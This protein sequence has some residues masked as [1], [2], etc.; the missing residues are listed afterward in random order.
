M[1]R[2]IGL[3]GFLILVAS[4]GVAVAGEHVARERTYDVLHYRIE[5]NVDERAKQI[6]GTTSITLIPLR[7]ALS[8]VVL[9]AAELR[10]ERVSLGRGELKFSTDNDQLQVHLPSPM[11]L[12]DTLTIAVRYSASPRK[13]LYFIQPDSGYPDR[14]WQV[15][16]QGQA[17]DNHFWFPCYDYPNDKATSEMIVTVADRFTTVS[18]GALVR[19]THDK[20]NRTKTFHWKQGTPHSSYL[21]SL[22]VGEYA[23]L[24]D[25]WGKVPLSYYIYPE[26]KELARWSFS[27][28]PAMM[29]FFT[30]RIGP[31]PWERYAQTVVSEFIYGGMENTSASTLT[32]HTIHD[33]RAHLDVSSDGLVAHELAHQWWGDLLTCRDW[34]H[35]WLNEGFATY[36]TYAFFEADS[37][38]DY[39]A[40]H[41]L[42]TQ[43]NLIATD[44]GLDRRAIVR[45]SFVD[46]SDV[47][48][49]R[50]YGKG[51]CVLHMMRMMLGDQ[52]FTKAIKGYARKHAYRNVE[53]NDL[54]IA[55]E[56]ETGQNLYWFFNQWV[57]R[58][59]Y[60]EFSVSTRWDSVGRTLKLRVD[61]TQKHEEYT[62]S[63]SDGDLFRTPVDVEIWIGEKADVERIEISKR[64]HEFTF[65]LPERPTLVVFDPGNWI[66]KSIDF[67]R[68][69][70]ELIFQLR[71]ARPIDRALAARA[72]I[73]YR[74][75]AEATRALHHAL[76]EDSFWPVR[77][78]A[79]RSLGRARTENVATALADGYADGHARVREAVA[80]A[81]SNFRRPEV[82]SLLQRAFRRD[83]SD[84][85][86]IAA[87]R[88]LIKVDS[89]NAR[90]YCAE[91]LE[92]SSHLERIRAAAV[93][94]LAGFGDETALALCKRYTRYGMH[95]ELRTAAIAAL[96]K[97]WP[98][99]DNV[100]HHLVP[101]LDDPSFHVRL[102]AINAL[103]VLRHPAAVEHL[104]HSA[105]REPDSRL[106]RAARDAVARIQ[107][108]ETQSSH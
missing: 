106:R 79:A 27:K 67:P 71:H 70:D 97:N 7:S 38:F 48:D 105:E 20:K 101:L 73:L 46:P 53:T 15:W 89:V 108:F 8:Q 26:Q 25:R 99:D 3:L 56:E 16:S 49:S 40:Y 41:I 103:G 39:S 50:S 75:S 35:T 19:S 82:V 104:Q 62:K 90:A 6:A 34:S 45:T 74:D 33:E 22:V 93:R 31:Y 86:A 94:A 55:V 66:L 76:T 2:P 57:Y 98:V 23:E 69:V 58:G 107:Q 51:A 96:A 95:R 102:A 72:L 100:V 42:S 28:T 32:D 30:E 43:D 13:G 52:L 77:V 12:N 60:P 47:F 78:E 88:S 37:G 29:K 36:F 81:L 10:V 65:A 17:D 5:I 11:G 63:D 91:A 18:N 61:Q 59:G 80:E 64:S 24:K 44:V 9:D 4:A 84:A 87:M 92:R 83:P 1:H 14:P 85:V 21:I 54:K 68:T